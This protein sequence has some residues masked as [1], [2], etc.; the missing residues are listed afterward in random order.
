MAARDAIVKKYVVRLSAEGGAQ[1]ETLIGKGKSPARR[2]TRGADPVEGRRFARRR[3]LERQRDRRGLG[4]Q[5][6]PGSP[7]A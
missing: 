6:L 2:L 4:D 5:S 3:G 1:L 7:G